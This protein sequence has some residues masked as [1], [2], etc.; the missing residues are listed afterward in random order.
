MAVWGLINIF[1]L[2]ETDSTIAG[3]AGCISY[4][5]FF[6]RGEFIEDD[7]FDFKHVCYEATL[8]HLCFV[9]NKIGVRQGS[10]SPRGATGSR[11]SPLLRPLA[12]TLWAE[13]RNIAKQMLP[14]GYSIRRSDAKASHTWCLQPLWNWGLGGCGSGWGVCG[15]SEGRGP[16]SPPSCVD[17]VWGRELVG[18]FFLPKPD[19]PVFLLSR[20]LPCSEFIS[21]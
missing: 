21:A 14:P 15:T 10:M 4:L 11:A 1:P 17:C 19:C 7:E 5:F 18:P 20:P 13:Y 12:V 9:W 3:G 16:R 6:R 2:S 8:G